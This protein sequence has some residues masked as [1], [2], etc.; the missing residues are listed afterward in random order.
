MRFSLTRTGH[1]N[2]VLDCER[3]RNRIHT[4][5]LHHQAFHPTSLHPNLRPQRQNQDILDNPR[6]DNLQFPLL[7]GQLTRRDLAMHPEKQTVDA[8]G[9]WPL[10]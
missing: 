3:Y 9:A 4:Y 5:N 10:H 1:L 8:D 2:V 6:R 7:S